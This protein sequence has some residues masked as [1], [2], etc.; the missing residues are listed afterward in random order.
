MLARSILARRLPARSAGR[1]RALSAAVELKGIG[2]A[3][4][5]Q[6]VV[7]DGIT[8]IKMDPTA[9]SVGSHKNLPSLPPKM[10][11]SW[12]YLMAD[13]DD[14]AKKEVLQVKTIIERQQREI[15][16]KRAELVGQGSI[17]WSSWEAQLTSPNAKVLLDGFKAEMEGW[18]FDPTE[19][20][21]VIDQYRADFK[22]M[23]LLVAT[24]KTKLEGEIVMLKQQEAAIEERM[25]NVKSITI[26]EL[27]E[28]DPEMAV[29][30]EEEIRSDNWGA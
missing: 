30:V 7:V 19:V 9:A 10:H 28:A 17:D 8:V 18:T 14:D 4:D 24:E 1:F 27:M 26:A 22:E 21:K 13:L 23:E 11:I 29:E 6:D 16:L 2:Q 15:D 20:N 3:S 25:A 12:D 5:L